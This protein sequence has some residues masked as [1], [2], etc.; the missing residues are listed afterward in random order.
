MAGMS[1]LLVTLFGS[2]A[3][4]VEAPALRL[5][6]D[7][8]RALLA[9]LALTPD[10]PLRRE[11]L[12]GIFWP[13]Q[14]EELARQNLRKTLGRLKQAIAAQDP[15]LAE[16]VL[17]LTKQTIELRAAACTTDVVT[18]RQRV[19]A[20]ARHTHASLEQCAVC[21]ADLETAVGLFQQGELLA[22]LSLPD[23]APFE[24]WLVVQRENVHQQQLTALQRL[25]GAFELMGQFE[26]A[27]Q[28]AQ[29]QIQLE[30]WRE[31]AHR[32]LMQ[33][34]AAQG[35]RAEAIAQYQTCRRI[36]QEELAVA[37]AAETEALLTQIMEGALPV[38]APRAAAARPQPW[39]RLTGHLIGREG[40]IDR[41]M[42]L[43][44]QP[45]CR[46]LTVTGVGGIG[47]TSLVL[48]VG[49]RLSQN[50]PPWLAD[51][52]Y[53]VPL[54]E[55]TEAGGLPAA[56]A[57]AVG[58]ALN[59]RLG[60]AAQVAQYLRPKAA[61]LILDNLEQLA[62][63]VGWL[64]ELSAASSQLK[65]LITSREP[66]N[67]QGEWRYPLE[68]LT[69]PPDEAAGGEFEAVQLFVQAARQVKPSFAYTA[70]NGPA[71]ARICRLVYGW[72][73]AL[74]MAA[75]W[76]AM[77]SCAAIAEQ[78]SASLD[79]LATS[80]QDLPRRQRSMRVIFEHTWAAL[81]AAEQGLLA[82]LAVFRGGFTLAAAVEVAGT[83]PLLLRGLVD[84][85]LVQHDDAS[86]R[87]R[88]HELLRQFVQSQGQAARPEAQEA[89]PQALDAHGRYYLRLLRT[90]G[91]RLNTIE[92]QAA[93]EV[94]KADIDNLH[95]AWL[96][97]ATQRQVALLANNL[98]Q[99]A[100][101][102]ES[103]GL[104]QEAVTVFRRTIAL[105][106][107]P[108]QPT[109]LIAQIHV[110]LA[111]SLRS[112]GQYPEATAAIDAAQALA[113]PLDDAALLNR[114]FIAQ[115]HVWREQGRYDEA[116]AVLAEAIAFSQAHADLLGVAR[117][118]HIQ[119]NTYWS[120]AAY[121]EARAAYEAGAR[122]Y[123]QLGDTT[124]V[125]VLTGNIGVVL[126]RLGDL[127]AALANYEIALAALRQVGHA[128]SVAIWL[129]NIGLIYVDMHEDE[130]AL[131]YLDE[132]L[133]MH[134]QLGRKYYR[135]EV[136]L[137]K[138]NLAVRR[139]DLATAEQ[140]HQQAVELSYLIG[141][142]TYLRDCDLW[143][144]RLYSYSGRPGEAINLLQSLQAREFRPD[145]SAVIAQ[146][147][148]LLLGA[149][150][151]A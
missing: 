146:E 90:Q 64:N 124:S 144:A 138:V 12:A 18:F 50:P 118:L 83:V 2:F 70:E 137:G 35:R 61:L 106:A 119:G 59:Q 1:A 69:Y 81:S 33:V 55:V 58:L 52:L 93:L 148:A 31:E 143:Q 89:Q 94:I 5:P 79:F 74:R 23:A 141:N 49:E 103:S 111:E 80:L 84:K 86:D 71:I 21:L 95:Q 147:L 43:L 104:T 24:A 133:H 6:T 87:F 131:A 14:P 112:L 121:A 10:T 46:V 40:E 17:S 117:A 123:Q 101:L 44:A 32:Q 19:E 56:V 68:G 150:P 128:A 63:E 125:A 96:W 22:G 27:R 77:L 34:L 38:V 75:G 15:E 132:S 82:Q 126:W 116:Q 88:L 9:Y 140:L 26:K 113:R 78:I 62:G 114:L 28:Y 102:Y 129:G 41:L 145:V 37:P 72:P 107:G 45:A 151:P 7:K 105:L 47:K 136:L 53:L 115:A 4:S 149:A 142:G 85:S 120:M 13:E 76:V 130:R 127:P 36:L 67:W 8:T 20:V 135:M 99:M 54:A 110:H 109:A 57:E 97:A 108:D 42:E 139:G 122:L 39:P 65:L 48:A 25:A 11:R 16:R 100:K 98:S 91:D 29:A 3:A 92:F 60:I 66:L 73:L 51:G 134:D 30:P